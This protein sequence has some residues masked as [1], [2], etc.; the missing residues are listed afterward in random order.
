MTALILRIA[1]PDGKQQTLALLE[2]QTLTA[3]MGAVYTL[4]EQDTQQAPEALVLKRKGDDLEIE[5]E[6]DLVAH[7][8]GFYSAE[9]NATF[10]ADGTVTP[11]E[12]MAVSSSDLLESVSV[13]DSGEAAVVWTAQ[14]SADFLGLPP[15]AWAGGLLAGA[16]GAIAL[17][18][19]TDSYE[20]TLNPAAGPFIAVATVELYDKNGNLLG[21]KTHDFSTGPVSF[22]IDNG[23]QGPLLAKLIDANGDGG[24]YLDET[25]GQLVSLGSSLRAMTVTDGTGNVSMSITPL[26]ELAVRQAGV[27]DDNK[28]TEENVTENEQVAKLFGVEDVLALVTTVLD[29]NYNSID[30]TSNAEQYGNVL[31]LLSGIDSTTGSIDATLAQLTAFMVRQEDGT[32]ALTQTGVELLQAGVVKFEASDNADLADLADALIVGPVIAAAKN[33]INKAEADQGVSVQVANVTA[34]DTVNI[35]WGD[36][37]QSVV[38]SADNLLEGV[39]TILVPKA[40]VDVAGEGSIGITSQ[41]NTQQ[42]SP[43]TI[44]SVDFTGPV[45]S[46]VNFSDTAL[47]VGETSLVTITFNEAVSGFDINDITVENAILSELSVT[48]N[49][50]IYTAIL[51]PD[52]GVD[53]ATN[54]IS[55]GSDYTNIEGNTGYVSNSSNYAID[56][57]VP[58]VTITDNISETAI[59]DVTYTFTFSENVRLFGVEDVTVTGGTKGAFTAVSGSQYTLVVTPS[60]ESVVDIT[61]NVAADIAQDAA[62]NNNLVASESVQAVDTVIP[63]VIIS[64]DTA[65]TATGDVTYTFTF[66][67]NVTGFGVEDVTV[68]GGTKGAFTAISGSQYTLIVTPSAESVVDITV[69]VAADIAQDAAG[70]NNLVASESVQAVDTVI[71][72][73]IISDDTTATATGEVIYTFTFNEDID[74]SAADVTLTGG[75]KGAFIAVSGSQYTLVVTPSAESVADITVNVAADIAQDAAGNNNLVAS[76]SVQAVD[77]VIPTVIISDDTAATATG[78]VTYTF[79]FSENVTGFGVEDVT[80]TGGTKGAFTAL[81]GSQYTLIVTPSAESVADI[82]VNVAADIAQDAAGNNNLVASESV[83]AVDTV[84]PTVII[85]D[86][87]AATATGDVTYTFTFSENVTGFGVEDVTVTGGTKGAFT[88]VSGSQYTLIVTP[89]AESVA[90]ITVNVAADIAQDA[91]GNNNLVATESVQA[92]DTVIPTVIISDDT[93]ATATGDVTY[94]FTFSEN[95]TGFSADDVTLTGG[96]KGAF[97]VLSGSQ[98]TLVVTPSAESVANITVNVPGNVAIDAVGNNSLVASESVQAVDTVIPTVI[99]SD[100]TAA[101]ATGDVTYTFTFSENVTGFGVE[102]VTVTGGKKGAFTALSGSQYTLIVTPSAE[103]V[104]DIT[105]NVA[106]D[107]AQDAAGN[108]NLVASESVQAVDTVDTVIPTVIISDDT[109]ATATGDVTYTFTF[110]EN[111]TGFGVEDVTVTGGTKGAF[112][113]LSGS[114]YTLVVTPSA[115]SVADIT[116]NVAADIAQDAAG[117]NNLV[118]SESVQAVDTV[119]PTVIIS[120]DTA[121]TATGDVTYTFTFSENVTGFSADDV[122][123]T[124]G[125]KGAFTVLSGSQYTLVVTPSAESVADITVNVAADIAQDAAG[126]NNLVASE[127]V[128]AVDTVIPTVIISDDTAATAT[129]D[130]TYTFTFSENVTGFSA[131]DVTLTGGTKGAFT[132][133]SGSQYTLVVTPSAESVADITVNVAANVAQDTAAN[134]S[135]VATESVQAVDTVT[136]SAVEV[137][138]NLNTGDTTDNGTNAFAAGTVYHITIYTAASDSVATNSTQWTGGANL[139]GDDTFTFST[140]SIFDGDYLD[141]KLEWTS[142]GPIVPFGPTGVPFGPIGVPF[143]PI[144]VP[145][146]PPGVPVTTPI[147]RTLTFWTGGASSAGWMT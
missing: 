32:L 111:V 55:L 68:T 129:G 37:N 28:V 50:R 47:K 79:T 139:D 15:S 131:D 58:T 88:A 26:S 67:E 78:D 46:S 118:A 143:G 25:T 10:S 134:N 52:A 29:E 33:G 19:N 99:I 80:V 124:G 84:I 63:T 145:F 140:D 120:D 106:A 101:T 60:A 91:A 14:E 97:T 16:A 17:V 22:T 147:P 136:S 48:D 69:N 135:L 34:G 35:H 3:S 7:I 72:T 12:G 96:T 137:F 103:S 98:Y 4:V 59:D 92:V 27:L 73:V 133:L 108:N 36:Q 85:S 2:L 128:Q 9:M 66:S 130:V 54:L 56:T 89:S 141:G 142:P 65:A 64:D 43:A 105:V 23:Y 93:A 100:D 51:T 30:G 82:T 31:A 121:A 45:I 81:S 74:F 90:D 102:D 40:K 94:T 109:A 146:G 115:E 11:S 6:G 132:A 87:T 116:V 119:I 53:D 71:P 95:V 61:V 117:N 75:T 138:F 112:T 21:S 122:T 62:G 123:L 39:A 44:I 38:V 70:N 86:D 20:V 126:N 114:Q 41:I 110:S 125:T 49:P 1:L 18:N 42:V 107:I 77:T 24:D 76:E 113:T 144:G 127:S 104:A 83:Q 5:V 57:T 13:S 8:D